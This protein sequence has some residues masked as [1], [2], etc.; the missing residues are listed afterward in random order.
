V[1]HEDFAAE[2]AFLEEVGEVE[3]SA[4]GDVFAEETPAAATFAEGL[5]EELGGEVS[6]DKLSGMDERY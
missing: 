1:V 6:C 3:A 4:D 5:L 2:L